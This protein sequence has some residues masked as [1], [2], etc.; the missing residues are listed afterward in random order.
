MYTLVKLIQKKDFNTFMQII[1]S[2]KYLLSDEEEQVLLLAPEPWLEKALQVYRPT[3][4]GEKVVITHRSKELVKV[5]NARW[6][7]S[8]DTLVWACS[9]RSSKKDHAKVIFAMDDLLED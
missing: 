4:Y 6:G 3:P 5:I 1:A 2:K 9:H 7:L 8:Y